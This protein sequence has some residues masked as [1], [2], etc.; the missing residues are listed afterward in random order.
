MKSLDGDNSLL[1]TLNRD[2]MTSPN[3]EEVV[4]DGAAKYQS[5]NQQDSTMPARTFDVMDTD[6]RVNT[7]QNTNGFVK[8]NIQET[9]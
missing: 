3:Q 1:L 6:L 2:Q 4:V 9:S 7:G 5:P 8:V